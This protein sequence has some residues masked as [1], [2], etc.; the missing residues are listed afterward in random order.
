MPAIDQELLAR[1]RPEHP[2]DVVDGLAV[3]RTQPEQ[4][5][6]AGLPGAGRGDQA[7]LA[8]NEIVGPGHHL[9][10]G[11]GI[12]LDRGGQAVVARIQ[13]V[14]LAQLPRGEPGEAGPGEESH[15]E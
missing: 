15:G 2:E 9:G 8:F 14:T 5:L 4:G 7:P 11:R 1:I 10:Q 13:I 3:H 12:G 6:G